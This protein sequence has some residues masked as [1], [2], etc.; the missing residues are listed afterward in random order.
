[1]Q[2]SE[3]YAPITHR[4]HSIWIGRN[5]LCVRPHSDNVIT[6]H[7]DDF[8]RLRQ[9]AHEMHVLAVPGE[10]FD[11]LAAV[12]VPKL[13]FSISST[14]RQQAIVGRKASCRECFQTCVEGS[15][16]LALQ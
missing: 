3:P 13:H 4:L 14:C 2:A 11:Q 1:M 16:F 5:G 7:S 12:G 6:A 8:A 9:E 10:Y 15:D